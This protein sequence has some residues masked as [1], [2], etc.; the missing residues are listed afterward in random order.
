MLPNICPDTF[1][2]IYS[3]LFR[4]YFWFIQVLS[5]ISIRIYFIKSP[6]TSGV[7]IYSYLFSGKTNLFVSKRI[8]S[9][10]TVLVSIFR[11]VSIFQL[12][13]ST[14]SIYQ[15][16]YLFASILRRWF[17]R[18]WRDHERK[19]TKWKELQLQCKQMKTEQMKREHNWSTLQTVSKRNQKNWLW[20]C[21]WRCMTSWKNVFDKHFE[22]Y[23][24]ICFHDFMELKENWK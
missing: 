24:N 8:Y 18:D 1:E 5:R 21:G 23:E 9:Y 22:N 14:I 20:F 15:W 3:Y 6:G 11:R 7:R 10:L 4:I 16:A 2:D 19:Q 12:K 17:G 13:R